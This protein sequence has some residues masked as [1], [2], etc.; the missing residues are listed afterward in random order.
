MERERG[1]EMEGERGNER[2][3]EGERERGRE[4]ERR[5]ERERKRERE[6][7]RDRMRLE[8]S[9]RVGKH[10][11]RCRET[12]MKRSEGRKEG[13]LMTTEISL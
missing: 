2:V 7:E 4:S 9:L 6:G 12:V 10:K 1:T 11:G 3:R 8:K 13:R 5:R